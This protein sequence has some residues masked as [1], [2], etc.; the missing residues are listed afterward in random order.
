[1][2]RPL[3]S[4]LIPVFNVEEYIEEALTSICQQTYSNLEIIIVDDCSTDSTF[5]ILRNISEKDSRIKLFQ[6]R[7]NKK[8]ADTLN[9]ALTKVTGEYIVRMD[10]DDISLPEKIEKQ[11]EYL[12]RNPDIDLVGCNMIA[13]DETGKELDRKSLI[14]R[15][16]DLKKVVK[17]SSPVPHIW[18]TKKDVYEDVGKYRFPGVEDYDFLLRMLTKGYKFENLPEFLYKIRMR[19]GNT[20]TSFG[21]FQYRNH[22][23]AWKAFLQREKGNEKLDKNIYHVS[24]LTLRSF[25]I[26]SKL[27]QKATIAIKEQ[28]YLS[29]FFLFFLSILLSPVIRT[30]ILI[31]RMMYNLIRMQINHSSKGIN[32]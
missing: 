10:G 23:L 6:N 27:S 25:K 3:I 21:L 30:R 9:F 26:S 5:R 18:L 19:S 32:R 28:R 16:E 24:Q 4:V 8:I 20:S 2:I 17:Y 12:L 29:S 31:N 11:Y 15:F 14:L 22:R 7:E 1:M 13:I